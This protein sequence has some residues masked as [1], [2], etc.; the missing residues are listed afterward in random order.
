MLVLNARCACILFNIIRDSTLLPCF[1][2]LMVSIAI[3]HQQTS[4]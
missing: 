3:L 2:G 4:A 1:F